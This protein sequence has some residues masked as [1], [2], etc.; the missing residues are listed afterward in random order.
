MECPILPVGS[1]VT[2][3]L[4]VPT[5]VV[6]AIRQALVARGYRDPGDDRYGP[7][8]AD[9][10]ARFQSDHPMETAGDQLLGQIIG[11]QF[12]FASCATFS[13]L[14][15]GCT[16]VY[17]NVGIWEPILGREAAIAA[18]AALA[19]AADRGIISLSCPA[20]P[21]TQPPTQPPTPAPREPSPWI[22]VVGLGALL[23]LSRQQGR[24]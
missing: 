13:A 2:A 22:W 7:A 4:P 5:G 10:L 18:G 12:A 3:F 11:A 21:P 16:R 9:E 23:W 1:S 14:G 15:L 19:L 20:P 8:L 6:Q 17:W 24:K